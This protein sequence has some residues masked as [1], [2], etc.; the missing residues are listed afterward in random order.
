MA[1]GQP[2]FGIGHRFALANLAV[3][4]ALVAA[5]VSV[6]TRAA[7]HAIRERA[8]IGA[9]V[10][11]EQTAALCRTRLA[12][13]QARGLYEDLQ[14]LVRLQRFVSIDVNDPEG[15]PLVRLTHP[16]RHRGL[17]QDPEGGLA[18]DDIVE[19]EEGLADSG[20]ALGRVRIGLWV[21]G[22]N[23]D[24]SRVARRGWATGLG[25][26]AFLALVSWGLG[27]RLSRRLRRLTDDIQRRGPDDFSALDAR[28][29]DEV[30][31]LASAFNRRQDRLREERARREAAE[32]HRQDIVHMIVHDMKGPL[33][34][35]RSGMPMVRERVSGA[36]DPRLGRMVDMLSEGAGRLL[37]MAEGILNVARVE[38]PDA[39]LERKP[40]DL[41]GLARA[42]VDA[43]AAG[44]KEKGV[45]VRLEAAGGLPPYSGDADILARVLDN[46]L[47]NAVEHT[48]K[49]GEVRLSLA[50]RRGAF[51]LEVQDGGPGVPLAERRRIFEKFRK[52]RAASGGAGLGLAFCKLAVERHGGTIGVEDGP[53]GKGAVFCIGL[54]SAKARS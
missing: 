22:I 54:E 6:Q 15:K 38:D 52:G 23:E 35:F 49:G 37:R 19:F 31:R 3:G 14:P 51:R 12:K 27:A 30:A 24:L 43:A 13:G 36:G 7:K 20:R 2:T 47:M 32:A 40:L 18:Q 42:R 46:L 28:G 21:R 17:T 25:L 8:R 5:L 33:S 29:A 45:R 10:A 9:E 44:G 11:L 34:V 16:E 50:R 53:E 4:V 41:E 26:C 1:R 48:P 39:P